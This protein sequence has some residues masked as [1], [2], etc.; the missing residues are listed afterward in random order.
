MLNI[1]VIDMSQAAMRL[2]KGISGSALAVYAD[3]N[4]VVEIWYRLPD[5]FGTRPMRCPDVL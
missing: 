2:V 4:D 1:G 3:S 5:D